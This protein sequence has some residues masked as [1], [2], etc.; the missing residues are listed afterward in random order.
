MTPTDRGREHAGP[1][2]EVKLRPLTDAEGGGW[3]AEILDLPGCIADGETRTE[4]LEAIDEAQAAWIETARELGRPIPQPAAPVE[5]SGKFTLR[6]PKSL[7][8]RLAQQARKEGVSLNQLA[9]WLLSDRLGRI[10]NPGHGRPAKER[11]GPATR[12]AP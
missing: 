8:R 10:K 5:Y 6:L 9:V 2:Y 1:R 12:P 4:A 3:L 11:D 7:H